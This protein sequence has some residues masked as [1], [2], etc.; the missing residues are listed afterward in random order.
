MVLSV[1]R[2]AR[3]VLVRPTVA[4]RCKQDIPL[5]K[6]HKLVPASVLFMADEE[7]GRAANNGSEMTGE[8]PHWLVSA[9]NGFDELRKQHSAIDPH[10]ALTQRRSRLTVALM[11]TR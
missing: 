4:N 5:P 2:A 1:D 7:I 8:A 6:A 9:R 3:D 11:T 10:G